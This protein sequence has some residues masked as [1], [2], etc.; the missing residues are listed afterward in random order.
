MKASAAVRA[1]APEVQPGEM[2]VGLILADPKC[3]ADAFALAQPALLRDP[4]HRRIFEAARAMHDAGELI[5]SLTLNSRIKGDPAWRTMPHDYLETLRLAAPVTRNVKQVVELLRGEI[6]SAAPADRTQ[7]AL[8]SVLTLGA[9]PPPDYLIKGLLAPNEVSVI[10]GEP[11]SGKSFLASWASYLVAV[12]HTVLGRRVR[13][14]PVV[15]AALEGQVGFE[16]RLHALKD[17]YGPARDFFWINQP[18]DLH[19]GF[20]DVEG[21]IDAVLQADARL[22]VIDTLARA[23][24]AGSENEGR[25]MGMVITALDQIR[26]ETG[27]HVAIVHHCGK[28]RDR[29]MRGHSSL[30]GAADMALEVK[31]SDSGTRSVRIVKAKDGKDGDEFGFSLDVVDLGLDDDGDTITTCV[32]VPCE[33]EAPSRGQRVPGAAK[34]A[35]ALL[36]K[37]V[38]EAGEDAPATPHIPAKS[39][40]IRL[41]VWR[42]YCD[43][44]L[45]AE[46][47]NPDTKRK[48][49]VRATAKL[50]ELGLIGIWGDFAW[51]K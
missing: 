40:T 14:A 23:M 2:L 16:R 30:L 15:Y 43:Q 10:Y 41:S 47:D 8:K 21:L 44:G 33:V 13:G 24:G 50:Q 48:A 1:D 36:D 9:V 46:S 26:R 49:F 20:G 4:F 38:A 18:A 28:D 11:G 27:A 35:L 19:S 25:D 45:I 7:Y 37:A 6:G 3:R 34:A 22:L 5:N 29:G 17:A 39:R 32:V 42:R 31:R 12:G 51:R